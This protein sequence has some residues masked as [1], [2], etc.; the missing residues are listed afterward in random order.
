M[1]LP[2]SIDFIRKYFF[3]LRT[4]HFRQVLN[5]DPDKYYEALEASIHI[6]KELKTITKN[7]FIPLHKSFSKRHV[8]SRL[9]GDDWWTL[10]LKAAISNDVEGNEYQQGLIKRIDSLSL[11]TF[12]HWEL[13]HFYALAIRV[14]LFDVGYAIRK[15]AR[16]VAINYYTFHHQLKKQHLFAL[17]A[18][19]LEA[20]DYFK[21]KKVIDSNKR[22]KQK[23]LFI[24]LYEVLIKCD[25]PVNSF[26]VEERLEFY[27]YIK[28]K[29]ISIVGPARTNNQDAKY[30]DSHDLVV[31]IN[32][33]E[34]G[35]GIDQLVKG[36]RCE[37]VYI[38]NEQANHILNNKPQNWPSEIRWVVCKMK[39]IAPRVAELINSDFK[40]TKPEIEKINTT[41]INNINSVLFNG[42][43]NIIPNIIFDILLF[44]PAAIRIF[45]ADLMLTV[46]RSSG[47]YPDDWNR[48]KN[49][50]IIFL[51]SS[52]AIHD[53][54]TQ[55]WFLQTLWKNGSFN[56]DSRF[57]EVMSLGEKEYMHQ[58]QLIYG[59]IGR[60]KDY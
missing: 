3:E 39:D 23:E 34:Q 4:N 56:G 7:T 46:N 53:P 14:G 40:T 20:G 45:H 27:N 5:N 31:R 42:S 41:S 47:Y 33:K 29:T 28:N 30:I 36:T 6:S 52:A 1:K 9:L 17:L 48:E 21:F 37:I 35:V 49:M 51:S 55:Y 12:D 15:K 50:K 2:V 24:K 43:F 22:I 19:L 18:A 54:V 38:N 11:K 10:F 25:E 16:E 57:N 58:L 59:D 32:Y 26:F 8:K 13:L 44:K 60:L